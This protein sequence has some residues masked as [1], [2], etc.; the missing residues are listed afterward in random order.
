MMYRVVRPRCRSLPIRLGS[1]NAIQVARLTAVALAMA[2]SLMPYCSAAIAGDRGGSDHAVHGAFFL[3]K[4]PD[5]KLVTVTPTGEAEA[6]YTI[7]TQS[8]AV[9][10]T[11]PKVTIDKFGEVYA[12]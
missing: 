8:V 2:V 10:E 12:F 5:T 6:G 9:K 3:P 11:G 4:G 1:R 7:L